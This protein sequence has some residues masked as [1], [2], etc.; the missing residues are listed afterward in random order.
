VPEVWTHGRWTVIPGRE[1]DFAAAWRELADWTGSQFTTA[2][3]TLLRD[4]DQ[5]N[6]F[7][8]FGPWPDLETVG[9]WRGSDGFQQ[10]ISTI[11]GL[12]ESFEA[13]TLDPVAKQSG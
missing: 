4:R 8:S 3:A 10:R 13:H 9:R 6:V 12:L 11:R 7:F 2:G 5:P 1:D